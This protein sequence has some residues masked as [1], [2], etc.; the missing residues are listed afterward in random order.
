VKDA[1][2]NYF[3]GGMLYPIISCKRWFIQLF[4]GNGALTSYSMGGMLSPVMSWEGYSI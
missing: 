3:M 2:S 1:L 4:H